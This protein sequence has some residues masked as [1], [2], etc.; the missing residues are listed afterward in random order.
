MHRFDATDSRQIGGL[1]EYL[2]DETIDLLV[3]NACAYSKHW[4]K[5][6]IGSIGYDDG[7]ESFRVNILG[8]MRVT[9][10]WLPQIARGDRPLGLGITS[11]MASVDD[12]DAPRD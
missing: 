8:P 11:H 4:G 5:D 1:P 9:G 10:K 6:P 3:S 12:I 7:E 2:R